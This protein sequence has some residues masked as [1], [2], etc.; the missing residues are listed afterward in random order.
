MADLIGI[1][2]I[3]R[4]AGRDTTDALHSDTEQVSS[5]ERYAEANDDRIIRWVD[6]TKSISGKTLKRQGLQGALADV[7]EGRADGIIV[8]K[9]S[10]FGRDSLGTLVEI[11]KI[12]DA[13]KVFVA[14]K[15]SI[16]TR[17]ASEALDVL[18][19]LISWI[20]EKFLK[21]KTDEWADVKAYQI[22]SGI[23]ATEPYGYRKDQVFD[24]RGKRIGGTRLLEPVA[25]EAPW[26]VYMYEKRKLKWSW[27]TIADALNAEGVTT[28]AGK[29]WSMRTVRH[30]VQNPTYLGQV[31]SGEMVKN[32]AHTAI[33]GLDLWTAANAHNQANPNGEAMDYPLTGIIRCSGC[34]ATMVGKTNS[35]TTKAGK[36]IYRYYDCRRKANGFNGCPNPSRVRADIVEAEI[37]RIFR[38]TFLNS[39]CDM[40]IEGVV[41]GV[42]LEAAALVL[43]DAEADLSEF[44]AS[45]ATAEL[46][47][48][49]GQPCVDKGIRARMGRVKEARANF[50]EAQNA[51]RGVE[52]P[53]NLE[54]IWDELPASERHVFLQAS[55]AVIAAH[56][57]NRVSFWTVNDPYT[58]ENLPGRGTGVT[59]PTP[60][61]VRDAPSRP[62]VLAGK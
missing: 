51:V 55:F 43:A 7:Y 32:D 46:R 19:F 31:R 33:V 14:V 11:G 15:D 39:G 3:S 50:V 25:D 24:E 62:R 23:N 12:R 54:E 57:G 45:P 30:I 42:D 44:L 59:A 47:K 17:N 20:D 8:M 26:V 27:Q 53:E 1:K 22:D 10:R 37:D 28:R 48:E 9:M 29:Q 38:D 41:T 40:D 6:E 13:G 52:L 60:I 58:P 34:G 4:M 49:L 21:D 2:R 35:K 61:P 56:P 16:D 18:L 36:T 5:C